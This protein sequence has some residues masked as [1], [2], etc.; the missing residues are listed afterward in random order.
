MVNVKNSQH[1]P[2][3]R[4]YLSE[5]LKCLVVNDFERVIFLVFSK[6]YRLS[7]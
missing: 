3:L 2:L 4:G 1:S 5:A 6:L 7:H